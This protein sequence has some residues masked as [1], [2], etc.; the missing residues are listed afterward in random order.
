MSRRVPFLPPLELAYKP[1]ASDAQQRLRAYWEGEIL[2][3]ACASIRARKD[4]A[5]PARRSLI[6]AEDFDFTGAVDRFEEWAAQMFFG[7]EAMPTLMPN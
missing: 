1:D 4:G 5:G 7:G 3:R 2:D 6:V